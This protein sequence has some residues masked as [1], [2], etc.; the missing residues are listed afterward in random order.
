MGIDNIFAYGGECSEVDA[1]IQ[2]EIWFEILGAIYEGGEGE[3][4]C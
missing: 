1:S 3:V 4:W 2:D